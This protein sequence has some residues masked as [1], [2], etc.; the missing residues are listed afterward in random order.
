M[1]SQYFRVGFKWFD[2]PLV[3]ERIFISSRL[4][5]FQESSKQI[6]RNREKGMIDS[7]AA[8]DGSSFSFG[9]D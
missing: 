1:A 9:W 4:G 2:V 5:F 8:L 6:H 3:T 7:N